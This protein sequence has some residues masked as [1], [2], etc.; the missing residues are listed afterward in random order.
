M[1]ASFEWYL[2]WK[3][4]VPTECLLTIATCP[5]IVPVTLKSGTSCEFWF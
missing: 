3:Y 5:V 2:V 4:L 1:E